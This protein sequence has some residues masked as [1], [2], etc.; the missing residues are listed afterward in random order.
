MGIGLLAAGCE[1]QEVQ[2]AQADD[3]IIAEVILRAGASSQLAWLHRTRG[4]AARDPLVEHATVRIEA[5]HGGILELTPAPEELCMLDREDTETGTHGSCYASFVNAMEIVEG[6]TYRLTVTLSNGGNLTGTTSVPA[7]FTLLRPTTAS[8]SVMPL[9]QLDVSWTPSS[10]AWVYA[11]ETS[12]RGIR[13]ALEPY[14]VDVTR[15]PL[16][17]FGLS[18]S[19]RDTTIAFP[20]EFGVFDRFDEDLVGALTFLQQ[21]LPAGVT[22]EVVIA[23][24][25]RNYVN[26]ERGGGFN[27]S[28]TVRV[29]SVHGA[30]TG[31]FGSLVPRSFQVRVGDT[32]RPPC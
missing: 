23:A 11:A 25:D 17:L 13:A 9:T 16:R 22:A 15:D 7:D 18:V 20:S 1:L 19:A 29:P 24:A 14:H 3:V 27:P 30:G 28:G 31:V 6:E 21:G 8:C 10:G 4:S 2:L 5:A 26:W 32:S 12:L